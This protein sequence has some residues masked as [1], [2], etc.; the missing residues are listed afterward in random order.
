M[1]NREK[2]STPKTGTQT[3]SNRRIVNLVGGNEMF[4][5]HECEN[6][7]CPNRDRR[8]NAVDP[9]A[10]KCPACGNT[11]LTPYR[12]PENGDDVKILMDDYN[13]RKFLEDPNF[14]PCVSYD[15]NGNP[16]VN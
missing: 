12:F 13:R 16:I 3:A 2:I 6:V 14:V 1:G 9:N 7:R 15:K 8:P 4:Y 11:D 10:G 5:G